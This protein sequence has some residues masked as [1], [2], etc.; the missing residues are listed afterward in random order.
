MITLYPGPPQLGPEQ[1]RY[2][3]LAST[4]PQH[5]AAPRPAPP[6]PAPP[7]PRVE[8]RVTANT[9]G[10]AAAAGPAAG[11][12]L[13]RGLAANLTRLAAA[14]AGNSNNNNNNNNNS[15][16]SSGQQ[17]PAPGQWA[18]R[19]EADRAGMASNAEDFTRE[20]MKQLTG[21]Q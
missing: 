7:G 2:K 16:S 6:G 12:P 15:S 9:A 19:L 1:V 17:P 21:G 11:P 8:T 5:A 14:G 4:N 13:P 18:P 20:F 10:P 3:L